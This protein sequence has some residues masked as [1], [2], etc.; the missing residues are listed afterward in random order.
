MKKIFLMSS[1]LLLF[2]GSRLNAQDKSPGIRLQLTGENGNIIEKEYRSREAMKNDPELQKLGIDMD[3]EGPGITIRSAGENRHVSIL[4]ENG[5]NRIEIRQGG[6][7]GSDSIHP[8]LPPTPPLPP[9]GMEELAEEHQRRMEMHDSMLT[10]HMQEMEEKMEQARMRR[11]DLRLQI[12]ERRKEVRHHMD[13]RRGEARRGNRL[14]VIED[15]SASD[16]ARLGIKK[17]ELKLEY[18]EVNP[19]LQKGLLS[20]NFKTNSKSP[21]K[22]LLSNDENKLL[23]NKIVDI[24]SKMF[25]ETFEPEGFESGTYFLQIIQDNKILARKLRVE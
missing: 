16:A 11:E 19:E 18:L 6:A 15:L 20:I 3:L 2:L 23:I 9:P 1:F 22:I 4:E 25:E 8:P 7:F 14:V 12:E 17:T 21:V 13:A 24:N 5:S 10:L